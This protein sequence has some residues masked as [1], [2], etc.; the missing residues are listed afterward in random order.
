MEKLMKFL[1]VLLAVCW[2]ALT[3]AAAEDTFLAADVLLSRAQHEAP[4]GP[5]LTLDEIEKMAL[6][7]NPEI[8]VAARQ[9]AVMET[10][11]PAAGALDD[12]FLKYQGWGIPLSQPWNYNAAQTCSWWARRFLG[13]ASAHCVPA[14]RKRM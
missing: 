12:P 4:S 8:H 3:A 10:R 13:V 9:L 11:V 1:F 7:G 6:T 5:A 14:S 2:C